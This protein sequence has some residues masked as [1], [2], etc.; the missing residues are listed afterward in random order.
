MEVLS[1]A[2][3]DGIVRSHGVSCH[4]LGALQ[5]AAKT[6]WVQVDMARINPAGVIMD[7]DV[8]TVA[9]TLKRMKNAGKAVIAMKVLGAGRLRDRLDECLQYALAQSF[10]DCFTIGVES[11]AEMRELLVKIPDAS[12]RA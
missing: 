1:Q 12:V 5:T 6:D 3:E 8:P 11:E 4:T 2:R 7:A 10:I 9:A